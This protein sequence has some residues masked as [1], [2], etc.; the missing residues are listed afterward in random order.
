MNQ[1]P[2]GL[3][4]RWW[5]PKL[6]PSIVKLSRGLRNRTLRHEQQLI[7][8]RAQ[9]VEHLERSLAAGY[10]VLITPNHSAHYDWAAL[11]S[12]ADQIRQPLYFL[13]AWQVFATSNWFHRWLMQRIGCFSIDRENSD[14]Q[15]YRKATQILR[16]EPHPLVVF[17]EG[18][19]YHINDRTTPFHEGAASIALGAARRASRPI[20]MLPCA[21]KFWYIDDPG[22]QME[23]SMARLEQHLHLGQP[24]NMS[25]L[26]RIYRLAQSVMAI[27][28]LKYAGRV[29]SGTFRQRTTQLMEHI[30]NRL[31]AE[32]SLD[33]I[34]APTPVRVQRLRRLLTANMGCTQNAE[35]TTRR[36][37]QLEDL[38][39]VIQLFSYPDNY[40]GKH[41]TIE[42][43]AETMDKLEEDILTKPLPS[44]RGR[45]RAVIQ[46]GEPIRV[47]QHMKRN[48]HV[49][50]LT[51][52]LQRN[53]QSLLDEMNETKH[54]CAVAGKSL[55]SLPEA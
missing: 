34:A 13:T 20:V 9:G 48:S 42:R 17:P 21:I 53:V 40:L 24:S 16:E 6:T 14:H 8:I 7:R 29:G 30:L 10:G 3:P 5:E 47:G 27:K 54:H 19:I 50:N 41:P 4:P 46:F 15:A 12:V 23:R 51:K 11:Y 55:K 37:R 36:V 38:F 32:H 18:D 45:R 39:F 22:K 35:S 26:D 44:I 2:Y 28:E 43:L 33:A 49:R 52:K 25:L 1:Q 31:E